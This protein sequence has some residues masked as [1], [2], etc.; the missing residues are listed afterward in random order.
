MKLTTISKLFLLLFINLFSGT[1]I[2]AQSYLDKR[3]ND[4][5]NAMTPQEKIN[6][7]INSSFGGTPTNT[8]L[9]IA[10]F[11]MDDGPHGV[12]FADG[13]NG[14]TATAFPTGI[15]MASTWDQDIATKV[16]ESMGIEFWAFNR[17]EQLGPCIDICR[18]PRG[19]RSAESGGEDPY[20]AGNIGK[21]VAIGIQRSPIVAT[22]KHFMGESKQS[23]RTNMNVIATDRWLM[24]FS[25]YN[26]RT[27]VQ[28]AGVMSV[29]GGTLRG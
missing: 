14:R 10:G 26:F 13:R 20:L 24:D 18:D 6:Q 8:R 28:E 23:N 3:I 25:G 16:G 15:A 27:V 17:N 5:V 2:Q 29:M 7:L 9:S 19:G 1:N 11:I 22:V 4:L 21:S 12:R